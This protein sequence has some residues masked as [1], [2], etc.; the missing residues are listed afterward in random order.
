MFPRLNHLLPDFLTAQ[1]YRREI[2]IERLLPP[3]ER[4]AF[5]TTDRDHASVVHQN[6]DRP[7]SLLNLLPPH[8]AFPTGRSEALAIPEASA[9]LILSGLSRPRYAALCLATRRGCRRRA[10]G[11][12]T[13]QKGR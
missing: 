5:S 6:I 1:K 8:P 7:Q 13:E 2:D 9:H 10:V 12:A 3:V 4:M 11:A